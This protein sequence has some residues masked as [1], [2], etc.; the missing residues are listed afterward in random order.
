MIQLVDPPS[1]HSRLL[2]WKFK[3]TWKEEKE[4]QESTLT[5]QKELYN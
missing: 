1:I 2:M 3:V 5:T 4:I